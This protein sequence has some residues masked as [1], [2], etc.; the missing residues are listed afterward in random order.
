[1]EKREREKIALNLLLNYFNVA[2][3]EEIS[4]EMVD[5]F[6]NK[7]ICDIHNKRTIKEFSEAFKVE[8]RI[9]WSV[10]C[11]LTKIKTCNKIRTKNFIETTINENK[12]QIFKRGHT[13]K[14]IINDYLPLFFTYKEKCLEIGR[15]HV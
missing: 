7:F 8:D 1:M 14:L 4:N 9:F 5:N 3:A 10:S 2:S 13:V 6:S 11:I 15:A 12:I